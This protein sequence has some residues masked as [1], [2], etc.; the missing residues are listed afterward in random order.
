MKFI[1]L[2]EAIKIRY[3][4]SFLFFSIL[5]YMGGIMKPDFAMDFILISLFSASD[6]I[7]TWFGLEYVPNISELNIF[8]KEN[9]E[10]YGYKLTYFK[11]IVILFYLLLGLYLLSLVI[12]KSTIAYSW[13]IIALYFIFGSQPFINLYHIAKNSKYRG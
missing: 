7:T 1:K 6:T 10:K 5:V 11:G 3:I 2:I 4:L 8:Q 13:A 12:G 9:F